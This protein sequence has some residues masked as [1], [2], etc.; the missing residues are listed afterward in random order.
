MPINELET[1]I[2][3]YHHLPGLP[4]AAQIEEE[5]GFNLGEIQLQLIRLVEEQALY[6]IQLQ[7]QINTLSE[8]CNLGNN[9]K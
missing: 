2:N 9:E 6:I 5:G 8:K 4:S 3:R 7:D 1:F